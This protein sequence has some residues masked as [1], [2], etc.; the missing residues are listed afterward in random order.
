MYRIQLSDSADL[1]TPD[2]PAK[3]PGT[4]RTPSLAIMSDGLT[5]PTTTRPTIYLEKKMGQVILM[6]LI[7]SLI[8]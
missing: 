6:V 4:A 5:S 8:S 3:T 1:H 2:F 7:S